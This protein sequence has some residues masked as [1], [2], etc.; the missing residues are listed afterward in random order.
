MIP[1]TTSHQSSLSFTISQSLHKVMSIEL[2]M[3]SNQLILCH[4][5]SPALNLSQYQGLF[6]E[7]SLCIRWS[8]H[9]SFSFSSVLPMNILGSFP[10]ELN[11]LFPCCPRDSSGSSPGPQFESISSS[12]PSLLYIPTLTSVHDYCKKHSLDYML[13]K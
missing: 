11:D 2:V 5:S 6:N 10:L 9:W 8:K 4:P 12:V 7:T 1:Q 13:E 3:P